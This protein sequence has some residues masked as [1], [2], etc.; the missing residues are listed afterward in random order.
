MLL[1]VEQGL[2]KL[3]HVEGEIVIRELT[4][5]LNCILADSLIRELSIK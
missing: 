2:G 4:N 1:F 5:S 3:K